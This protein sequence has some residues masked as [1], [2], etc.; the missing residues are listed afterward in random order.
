MKIITKN[1]I[2]TR[3]V[4]NLTVS[5]N[6]TFITENGIV[7]HNCDHSN[8]DTVQPAL[9]S[10]METYESNCTFIFTANFPNRIMDALKSRCTTI[11]FIIPK[12]EV[13]TLT[14]QIFIKC[15]D[16]LKENNI[17]YDKLVVGKIIKKYFPD[18]RKTINELQKLS[19]GGEID[20][21]ALAVL[22]SGGVDDLIEI[23]KDKNFGKMR[24]WVASCPN[25]D[26]ATLCRKLYEKADNFIV[27]TSIP[28]MVIHI[29]DYSYKDS[30][31]ADKE[32]IVVAMLTQLMVSCDF[33]GN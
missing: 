26:M 2:G 7:T 17:A 31:V 15:T 11:E 29:A 4:R 3:R 28:D 16:I 6:H 27:N 5:N 25:L 33:K 14:K 23:L 1:K 20:V 24:K 9:R 21:S 30:F 18:F 8:G 12:N 13:D 22:E 10:F 32:I 19:S